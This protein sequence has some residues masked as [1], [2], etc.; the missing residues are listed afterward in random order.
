[1]TFYRGSN[2]PHNVGSLIDPSEPHAKH[3]ESMA[4]F[5]YFTT[6]IERAWFYARRTVKKFG[7]SPRVFEVE[8]TGYYH[9]D[10]TTLRVPENKQTKYPL[11]VI[12]EVTQ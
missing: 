4:G 6:D 1:M 8:P 7:G 2:H 10:V 11:R 12:E 3:H 9:Q 5:A